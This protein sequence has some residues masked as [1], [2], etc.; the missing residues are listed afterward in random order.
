[1]EPTLSAFAA[2]R[3]DI[4]RR[5]LAALSGE[6]DGWNEWQKVKPSLSADAG[7]KQW[8]PAV[9]TTERLDFYAQAMQL[10]EVDAEGATIEINHFIRQ[11]ARIPMA[12]AA[13]PRKIMQV[14]LNIGQLEAEVERVGVDQLPSDVQELHQQFVRLGMRE[15]NAYL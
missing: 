4:K 14:A 2:Y 6:W 7:E 8:S 1:M 5:Y 12:E 11:C 10:P 13:S 15:F 3:D 9:Q